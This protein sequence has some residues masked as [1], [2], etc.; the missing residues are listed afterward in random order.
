MDSLFDKS[1][2]SAPDQVQHYT[3]EP[4][5]SLILIVSHLPDDR[6]VLQE[7]LQPAG[8]QLTFAYSS[9]QALEQVKT[10][11]PDLVLLDLMMPDI[12][13]LEV[14]G[15]LT[16]D[17]IL[18]D[19]PVIFLTANGDPEKL[20]EA[21]AA[22]AVDF[23]TKPFNSAALLA[24][25]KT[26]LELQQ[27]RDRACRLAREEQVFSQ[28][29]QAIHRY[30]DLDDTL[31]TTVELL[32]QF[33]D[34][35]RVM[36]SRCLS[37]PTA[38]VLALTTTAAYPPVASPALPLMYPE[39]PTLAVL[40]S[41]AEPHCQAGVTG[42]A[43]LHRYGHKSCQ[44]LENNQPDSV[45]ARWQIKAELRAPIVRDDTLWGWLI[46]H[47]CEDVTAWGKAEQALLSRIAAQ[48]AIAVRQTDLYQQLQFS[49]ARLTGILANADEAIIA[50]NEAQ[51]I[52]LFNQ[53]AE[54]I[55][56]YSVADIQG[57]PVSQLLS[58]Q[59][60]LTA[61][62][63][64][65]G[66]SSLDTLG[67]SSGDRQELVG[68]R[69]DG[70]RFP[71]E[72]S[73]SQ[74][75]IDGEKVFIIFLKDVTERGQTEASMAHLANIVQFS[76]D[77]IFSAT[78]DGRILS[79]NRGAVRLFGYSADE[80]V[81]HSSERLIPAE[82]MAE[83]AAL[84][85]RLRQ[86]ESSQNF[87]TVRRRKD[88]T[89]VDVAL[90]VS[91]LMDLAET[92]AGLSIIA[93]DI[94]KQRQ[95]ERLKQQFISTVSHELRT[96]LTSINGA[97]ELLSTGL[98]HPASDR[99]Q[100][101]LQIAASSADRLTRLV[102]DILDLERLESGKVRI[103]SH[104]HDLAELMLRAVELMQMA[105]EQSAIALFVKPLPINLMM[106]DNRILQVLTNLL[107]NAIKFSPA[108]SKVTLVATRCTAQARADRYRQV[109]SRPESTAAAVVTGSECTEGQHDVVLVTVSDQGRGI[110][111]NK[112]QSIFE[113][114]QQVDASDSRQ[115][116][117]I[118]LGLAICRSIVQ[119]HG[120]DIWADSRLHEGSQFYFTLPVSS[121][122]VPA[123]DQ[124]PLAD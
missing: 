117:G 56:G 13:G 28:I 106:D 52:T 75:E 32:L 47:D 6:K 41:E 24:R 73:F 94:T 34:A 48:L 110:P 8:Y 81:G 37:P 82:R 88:G 23:L 91:P 20:F 36:V 80:I 55:F 49:Q 50:V 102:D 42:S 16:P 67:L 68:Q 90:T 93:R 104:L 99:G 124:T 57:H 95:I 22:G 71:A 85:D 120:G 65:P 69:R 103:E 29:T 40:H 109:A 111:A 64:Q 61:A 108:G 51:Q 105:A 14:I 10:A 30:L 76:N 26:H 25:V 9:R 63:A 70:T 83:M 53:G 87:E 96:P 17:P 1:V 60:T 114:F 43:V 123:N 59:P 86:G 3:I 46:A 31:Q 15:H 58:T 2:S 122:A 78:L 62:T 116:G 21:F 33:L 45:A 5:D 115:K 7:L 79:W 4:A 18:L 35:D 121:D 72:V 101:T 74:L 12:D 19:M 100:E 54:H 118:G 84:L 39:E 92:V 77:A 66:V 107:S 27:L 11:R 97:L 112:L 38:E 89:F 119:Q 44:A 98:I 113:R